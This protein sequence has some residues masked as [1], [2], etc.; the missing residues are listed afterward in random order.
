MNLFERVFDQMARMGLAFKSDPLKVIETEGREWGPVS[1]GL[2]LS[3]A[4]RKDQKDLLSV[5]LRN[6][7][8]TPKRVVTHGW[9]HFLNVHINAPLSAYGRQALDPGRA[10]TDASVQLGPH[11]MVETEIPLG[12]LFDLSA[13]GPYRVTI[14]AGDLK[15]NECLIHH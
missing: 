2:D 12:I 11:E 7:E 5:I 13:P 15:S 3:I 1:G 10:K 9:L 4:P 6:V 8:D 14:T